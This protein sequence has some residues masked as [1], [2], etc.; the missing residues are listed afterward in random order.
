MLVKCISIG[1]TA[2]KRFETLTQEYCGRLKHYIKFDY[3]E[4]PNIKKGSKLAPQQLKKQEAEVFLKE[5]QQNDFVILLD[6]KGKTFTSPQFAQQ[7]EKWNM[8]GQ[9]ICFI[10]G[11]AFGFDDALYERANAKIALSNMT[12]THQMV[13]LFFVEQLYR[14]QTIIAGEKYHH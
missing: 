1:K 4:L 14:A 7:I 8:M 10:I 6:E 2:D 5:I 9:N 12:L 13:R 3:K 11:G